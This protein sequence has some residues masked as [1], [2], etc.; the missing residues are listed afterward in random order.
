MFTI[1]GRQ[2]LQ[3][4]DAARGWFSSQQKTLSISRGCQPYAF[5]FVRAKLEYIFLPP[6]VGDSP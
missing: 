3:A 6:R 4:G 2:F 1:N 5:S